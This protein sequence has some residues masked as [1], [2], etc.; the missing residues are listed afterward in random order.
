MKRIAMVWNIKIKLEKE[1]IVT[2]DDIKNLGKEYFDS[3]GCID[4]IKLKDIYQNRFL[5]DFNL[6]K[7]YGTIKENIFY[8]AIG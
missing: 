7:D 8:T 4:I 5:K 3:S 1:Y 2:E 6:E